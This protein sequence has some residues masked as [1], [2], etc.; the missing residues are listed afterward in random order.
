MASKVRK[1]QYGDIPVLCALLRGAHERS[2][3]R[4]MARFSEARTKSVLMNA[5]QRDGGTHEGSV[6]VA[7][8]DRG[9]RDID[10]F[11]IG[12]LQSIYM[13]SDDL[14]ATDLFWYAKEGADATSARR[15]L[16]AMHKWATSCPDVVLIRQ[17]NTDAIVA[18]DL[19]GRLLER[20]GM[21][22]TG[23]IYE[24]ELEK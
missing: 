9:N 12:I 14:E 11:I 10:A 3:F 20:Q 24:K 19:S 2:R 18:R 7:V 6:F 21:R 1:A 4:A 23:S 17:A 16:R 13:L 22:M 8:S 5:I 15:V